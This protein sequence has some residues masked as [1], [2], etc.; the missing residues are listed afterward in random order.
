MSTLGLSQRTS[1]PAL[2]QTTL[3]VTLTHVFPPAALGVSFNPRLLLSRLARLAAFA[4][5]IL[6]VRSLP[7]GWHGTLKCTDHQTCLHPVLSQTVLAGVKVEM[8]RL[9]RA[10]AHAVPLI[11]YT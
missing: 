5:I 3:R 11:D 6:N 2:V 7:F 8:V 1:P 9:V 4:I 10:H